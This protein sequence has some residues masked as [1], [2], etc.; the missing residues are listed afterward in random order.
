MQTAD[1]QFAMVI[2][3]FSSK[4]VHKSESNPVGWLLAPTRPFFGACRVV[5]AT[6]LPALTSIDIQID[7]GGARCARPTLQPGCCK[8]QLSN[9]IALG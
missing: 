4:W 5:Q 1:P 6:T 9:F 3:Q 2:V 7:R 8:S